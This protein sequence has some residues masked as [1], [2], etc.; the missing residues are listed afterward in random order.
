[1]EW[2]PSISANGG[3]KMNSI[4]AVLCNEDGTG[5]ECLHFSWNQ[6][7]R[8]QSDKRVILITVF[9]DQ[10]PPD[11]PNKVEFSGHEAFAVRPAHD[12]SQG[13]E[14]TQVDVSGIAH[15]K[16]TSL[17]AGG[18]ARQKMWPDKLAQ[19]A[20]SGPVRLLGFDYSHPNYDN[21][22]LQAKALVDSTPVVE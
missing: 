6:F 16:D 11:P 14:I 3:E 8:V 9:W 7:A 22:I 21:L 5:M 1:M 20:L 12:G 2:R 19:G 18:S 13:I 15:A 4:A 17:H 10:N